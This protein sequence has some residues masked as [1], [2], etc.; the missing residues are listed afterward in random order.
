MKLLGS[1]ILVVQEM[2]AKMT[3]GGIALPDQS[4]TSLPKGVVKYVG[5]GVCVVEPGDRVLFDS[6]GG[7]LVEISGNPYVLLDEEDALV[8]L[9]EGDN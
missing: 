6:I 9:E 7:T 2:S 1:K 4:V 5:P 3:P 8:I